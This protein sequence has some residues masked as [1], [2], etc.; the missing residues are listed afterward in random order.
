M[1]KIL[2][3]FFSGLLLSA[4]NRFDPLSTEQISGQV[5]MGY[6]CGDYCSGFSRGYQIAQANSYSHSSQCD[7]LESD[8]H[9]GCRSYLADQ[10]T[11]QNNA[12][13]FLQ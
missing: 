9:L 10:I 1:I 13:M 6:P 3:S 7:E 4:C 12:G 2:L 11:E 5:F 8:Q